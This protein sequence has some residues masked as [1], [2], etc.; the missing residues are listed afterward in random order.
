MRSRTPCRRS[1]TYHNTLPGISREDFF[2]SGGRR[3]SEL[4]AWP[5]AAST[6]YW[7]PGTAFPGT[8]YFLF[9]SEGDVAPLERGKPML[10]NLVVIILTAFTLGLLGE[11]AISIY[12][13]YKGVALDLHDAIELVVGWLL[14]LV[15]FYASVLN[16]ARH[17]W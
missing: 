3:Q 14:V 12:D 10:K 8:D 5:G 15:T 13:L 2:Y 11:T 4:R 16:V 7:T 6:I 17:R 9:E 1:T